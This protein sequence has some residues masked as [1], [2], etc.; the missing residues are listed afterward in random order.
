[1]CDYCDCRSQPAIAELTAD[2]E[3]L[4][5]LTAEVRRAVR[6]SD[7]VRLPAVTRRLADALPPHAEREER[8]VFAALERV[9]ADPASV[10]RFTRDHETLHTLLGASCDGEPDAALALADLLDDHIA[11]EESDLFPAARQLLAPADWDVVDAV[12][13]LATKGARA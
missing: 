8:G 6:S 3:T 12:H 11:R 4:R 9:G 2:H 5:A 10:A 7:V 13:R 1:M